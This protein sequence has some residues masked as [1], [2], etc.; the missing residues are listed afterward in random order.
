ML[1]RILHSAIVFD[2]I[3]EHSGTSLRRLGD[4]PHFDDAIERQGISQAPSI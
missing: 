1:T 4:L 2:R 3:P